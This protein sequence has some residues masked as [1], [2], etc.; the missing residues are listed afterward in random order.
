[1]TGM[2]K[3]NSKD[4]E[5]MSSMLGFETSSDFIFQKLKKKK[6]FVEDYRA[7][8]QSEE[9]LKSISDTIKEEK[10]IELLTTELKSD[11][12]KNPKLFYYD[13]YYDYKCVLD[14]YIS[15][16]K[17]LFSDYRY[18]SEWIQFLKET[19]SYITRDSY[20]Q[21]YSFS[22]ITLYKTD[23]GFEYDAWPTLFDDFVTWL[24]NVK[25]QA[26]YDGNLT[27]CQKLVADGA[28]IDYIHLQRDK[29]PKTLFLYDR[30]QISP[31]RAAIMAAHSECVQYMLSLGAD[32]NATFSDIMP[33]TKTGEDEEILRTPL[34]VA[35]E[36]AFYEVEKPYLEQEEE[37]FQ[38]FY[39][40]L[41][42]GADASLV[43]NYVQILGE[44]KNKGFKEKSQQIFDILMDYMN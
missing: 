26:C 4:L 9:M 31:L 11:F 17:F 28:K 24:M 32:V 20:Q 5:K 27:H 40:L 15:I 33:N 7:Q 30:I 8:N 41:E 13:L 35:V 6:L 3:L 22:K 29:I 16:F 23:Y 19:K 44:E 34:R 42:A 14:Y 2:C 10:H 36:Y 43:I 18:I 37:I 1:M 12:L 21:F 38:I 39:L 25:I